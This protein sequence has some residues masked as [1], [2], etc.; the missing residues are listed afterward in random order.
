MSTSL[1]TLHM[2]VVPMSNGMLGKSQ[3][4]VT[5]PQTGFPGDVANNTHPMK[6]QKYVTPQNILH[7][8]IDYS[9]RRI[10]LPCKGL[11]H[12]VLRREPVPSAMGMRPPTGIARHEIKGLAYIGNDLNGKILRPANFYDV[13]QPSPLGMPK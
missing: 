9:T 4:I 6:L 13:T 3:T 7:D 10:V 11:V 1:N 8:P 5:V 12:H 2:S